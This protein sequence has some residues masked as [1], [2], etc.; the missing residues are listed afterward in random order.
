MSSV[1]KTSP[2]ITLVVAMAENRVIGID[3]GLPWRLPADLQHFKRVTMGKPVVM[4]RKTFES[5][6]RPL[7]G[8]RNVVVS[9]NADYQAEGCETFTSV[10]SVLE[11]LAQAPEIMVIGGANL[12][13]QLLPHAHRIHLT[14]VHA[15][16]PGD[17]YFPE[18]D[19]A[20]WRT[21]S[22]E[23]H[24]ADERNNVAYSFLVLER[25][26]DVES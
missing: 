20:R 11:C 17:A 12:Y 2:S 18:L 7:P 4:G 22:R 5:I 16:V 13:A 8:R 9:R 26:P 6:G 15:S 21:L 3:N 10:A 19:H 14:L 25:Q 23:D 1:Q 24:A